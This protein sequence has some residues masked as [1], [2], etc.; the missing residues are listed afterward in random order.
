M[1]AQGPFKDSSFEDGL[2]C[3]QNTPDKRHVDFFQSYSTPLG[4]II[5]KIDTFDYADAPAELMSVFFVPIAG[6]RNVVVLLRWNVDHESD[7]VR[8]PYHYEVKTYQNKYSSGY[9]LS[10]DL[11]KDPYL[12]GYQTINNGKTIDY[13][14]DNAQKIIQYLRMKYGT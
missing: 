11:D 2:I 8:Y 6:K 14:F 3:F 1:L 5:K 12:T 10:L 4:E 9:K 7:G 13:P